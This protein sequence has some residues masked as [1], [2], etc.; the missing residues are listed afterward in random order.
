MLFPRISALLLATSLLFGA[1]CSSATRGA[2]DAGTGPDVIQTSTIDRAKLR[3]ALAARRQESLDRF[4]AY[5]DARSY[6]INSYTPGLQHVW[7]DE[8]GRLCA[9]AT[10]ISADWGRDAAARIAA[11]NNFIMLA[12][13]H[14]GPIADWILTSGMTHHEI[15]AIQEPMMREPSPDDGKTLAEIERLH[16]IYTSVERQVHQLWDESLDE[17]VD[18]L[19]AHPKL[20]ERFLEG[21]LAAAGKYDQ[22]IG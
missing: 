2:A 20:A 8:Q 5:R 18:A 9:A 3:T 22:P 12:D 6:P 4:L 17:A 19:M 21:E 1:A 14:D 7:M 10:L 13:V 16:G 15:V 11:E